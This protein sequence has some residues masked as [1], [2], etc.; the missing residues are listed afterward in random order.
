MAATGGEGRATEA[1]VG[2]TTA[3]GAGTVSVAAGTGT[4]SA[5][6]GVGMATAGGVGMVV[7]TVT[8]LSI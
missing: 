1:G 7:V 3:A 2:I 4:V 6:A 5:V 8:A